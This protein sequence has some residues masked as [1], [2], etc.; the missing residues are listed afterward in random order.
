M[1]ST[2]LFF[3]FISLALVSC[4]S[5]QDGSPF[6]DFKSTGC[7]GEN[8]AAKKPA[9]EPSF[10]RDDNSDII[11]E[12]FDSVLELSGKCRLKDLPDSE[13]LIQITAENGDQQVLSTSYLPI[14]GV[15]SATAP[16]AKCEKGRW[17]VAIDACHPLIRFA[18]AHKIDL[19]LRGKDKN[20]R[21]V[22]IADGKISMNVIRSMNALNCPAL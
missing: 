20:K 10:E 16:V 5:K 22:D 6:G 11:L 7:E 8:C 17:S 14:V 4:S 12:K 3:I 21:S 9:P 13:I 18:G 2:F 1:K 15:T 19:E